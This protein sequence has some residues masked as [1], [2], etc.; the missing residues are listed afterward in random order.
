MAT[1]ASKIDQL[2]NEGN[3]AK[4][5]QLCLKR[6]KKKPKDCDTLNNLGSIYFTTNKIDAA[7][8]ILKKARKLC[9]KHPQICNNLGELYR[10]TGDSK[11]AIREF[12]ASLAISSRQSG[13]Y[14]N[15]G[16]LHYEQ[17]EYTPAIQYFEK[18]ITLKPDF[19][20]AVD[21][22]ALCYRER[23]MLDEAA[24]LH[25]RA[26]EID[27]SLSCVYLRLAKTLLFL[28]STDDV[29]H[30]INT[31]IETCVFRQEE[32]CDLYV[33]KAIV[34]WL[35]G[36]YH[37]LELLFLSCP[38]PS[39]LDKTYHNFVNIS[40]YYSLLQK[41]SRYQKENPQLYEGNPS[42]PLFFIGDSHALA[43]ANT[44]VTHNDEEYRVLSS[45]IID[46]KTY[47]LGQVENNQYKESFRKLL[48]A[49][50]AH[51]KIILGIGEIDCR[52]NGGFFHIYKSKQID[53]KESVPTTV[54]RYFDFITNST[55]TFNHTL[56][57]YGVPAPVD[58]II[59]TLFSKDDQAII[60]DIIQ[61]FNSSLKNLCIKNNICFLDTYTQTTTPTGVSNKKYHIDSYHLQPSILQALFDAT[62]PSIDPL[63]IN[64]TK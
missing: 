5:E 48:A 47:H 1:L 27:S 52:H 10:V 37:Q 38:K 30:V 45:V 20:Q 3:Y 11:S 39:K 50:P 12:E 26:N 49:Y 14:N 43:P 59:S 56:Y 44:V 28:H 62:T 18:A 8:H 4:A 13:P 61:L 54:E 41:L 22:M 31:A 42:N 63:T 16:V 6:I 58:T 25:L 34:L 19:A 9:T 7:F 33:A 23:G 35:T 51:S 15:I 32:L 46:C 17:R 55:A 21:N 60:K 64:R 2:I 29:C 24:R 53:Y 40:G 36:E 57:F